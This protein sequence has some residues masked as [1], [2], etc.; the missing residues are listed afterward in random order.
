MA[1]MHAAV[2][3]DPIAHSLSPVLHSAA[4]EYLGLDADYERL[5][6]GESEL[7]NVI[8]QLTEAWL[9]LSLTMPLKEIARELIGPR[10]ALVDD[11]ESANTIYRNAHGEWALANTDVEGARSAI[12]R[13]QGDRTLRTALVFGSGATARSVVRALPDLGVRDV[14]ITAR[15]SE[16]ARALATRAAAW[17]LRVTPWEWNSLNP[18]LA[19]S[20]LVVSAVP[21]DAVIPVHEGQGVLLDVAY[22]PWPTPLAASWRGPVASGRDM[23]VGQA[24]R[25]IQLMT[26][27]EVPAKVL[28]DALL[29]V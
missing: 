9:G 20:D 13:V 14:A 4:Y 10:E 22:H 19:A 11:V 28:Y 1:R 25:Q 24:L 6:V 15:R 8:S 27:H 21:G 2:C 18:D 5:R 26:G 12:A 23:L 29:V 16:P 17:G 3:G 7:A